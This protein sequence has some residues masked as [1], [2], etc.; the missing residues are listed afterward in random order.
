MLTFSINVPAETNKLIKIAEDF[1]NLP[2]FLPDQLKSVK[3]LEKKDGE[4]KTEETLLFSTII[5]EAK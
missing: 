4:I 5:P 3:I 2:S 1:E